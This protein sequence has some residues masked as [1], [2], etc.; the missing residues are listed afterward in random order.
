MKKSLIAEIF[1]FILL[2]GILFLL[3]VKL[4]RHTFDIG[5]SY[6][7]AFNDI[8]SIVIGSPVRILGVDVGHV[9]KIKTAPDK[10]YV[11]FVITDNNVK[12][13]PNGTKATIEFFGIAGSRSIELTPPEKDSED[14]GIIVS[15]PIRIGDAFDIMKE[16]LR[17]TMVSI[18]GLYEFAK[19]RTQEAAA[20]DT[21]HLL[22]ATN[23]ADDK[24]VDVTNIICE[25]GIKLHNSFIGTTKGMSRV[26][27]EAK[28]I[29][30]SKS[31]NIGRYAT[32]LTKRS[33]IKIHRNIKD[34]NKNLEIK[35]DDLQV[36]YDKIGNISDKKEALINLDKTM[37]NFSQTLQNFE[38][39]LTQENLDKV[40]DSL[41]E[42]KFK[43][44][45][46][47]NSI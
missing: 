23:E 31:I 41:E 32:N 5:Q 40:Y 13:L 29:N 1:L 26:N 44:E 30:F 36:N 16:F 28:R 21:A 25:G 24:I 15:D 33:L 45:E 22:K 14:M 42:L 37:E 34:L 10:I 7:V 8:D 39:N 3:G 17:A 27:E 20:N 38:K 35:A 9:T 18:A 12:N 2:L 6:H 11:E 43:S 4:F 46:L 47:E 19:G